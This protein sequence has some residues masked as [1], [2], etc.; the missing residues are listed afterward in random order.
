MIFIEKVVDYLET[1]IWLSRFY[2]YTYSIC[3]LVDIYI[4]V[5]IIPSIGYI[6]LINKS[7]PLR[8]TTF[9]FENL[10]FHVAFSSTLDF[11]VTLSNLCY[12]YIYI[13]VCMCNTISIFVLCIYIYVCM[14]NTI[15]IFVL[16]I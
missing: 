6:S 2:K 15:S 3:I 4:Y 10:G 13:C 8:K 16:C 14:C 1:S 11:S 7:L 5:I 9:V 12:V